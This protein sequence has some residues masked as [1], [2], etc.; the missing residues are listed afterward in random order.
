MMYLCYSVLCV[1]VTQSVLVS[2]KTMVMTTHVLCFI[3]VHKQLNF[4]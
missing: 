1:F 4:F 3:G 2:D